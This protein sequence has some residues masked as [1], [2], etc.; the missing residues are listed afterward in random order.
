MPDTDKVYK[1]DS[2]IPPY[3]LNCR[4]TEMKMKKIEEDCTTNKAL[5][6]SNEARTRKLEDILIRLN[7]IIEGDTT[8]T[9]IL[10]DIKVIREKLERLDNFFTK[11]QT[12]IELIPELANKVNNMT[13]FNSGAFKIALVLTSVGVGF[14]LNFLIR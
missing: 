1:P 10:G 13:F 2:S 4:F 14:F 6:I 7:L 12:N 11:H 3:S 9:G 5:Q 8:G